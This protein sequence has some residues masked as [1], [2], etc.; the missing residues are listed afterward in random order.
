ML[1]RRRPLSQSRTTK[2]AASKQTTVK[3]GGQDSNPRHEG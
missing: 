1:P 3:W 2:H